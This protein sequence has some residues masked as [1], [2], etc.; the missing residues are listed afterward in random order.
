MIEKAGEVIPAVVSVIKSK[1]S[2]QAQ[3]YQMPTTCPVCGEPAVQHKGEVALRCENLQCPAQTIR[4]LRH[5]ASRN[6]LDIE[7]LGNIVAEKLIEN[8]LVKSPLDLFS[9]TL[10]QLAPLNLGTQKEPRIFGAK[11]AAKLLDAVERA[12]TMPLDR[13]LFALGIPRIGKTV[14]RQIAEAHPHLEA[15]VKSDI[16]H[17]ICRLGSLQEK[18]AAINPD[19]TGDNRPKNQEE[20]A[21]RISQLNE[22]NKNILGIVT[23]LEKA[24][25]L[26]KKEIKTKK[27]GV[28]TIEIQTLIKQDAARSITKFF[29]SARGKQ[30]LNQLR[31]LKIN[32]QAKVTTAGNALQGKTFVLTGTLTTM[33]RD[34]AAELIRAQGGTV[35]N[36][37]T[38]KTTYLVAG[39]NTGAKKTEQAQQHGVEIIDETQLMTMLKTEKTTPAKK[40]PVQEQ[41]TLF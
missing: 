39:A 18:A 41:L 15:V 26:E 19:A 36:T 16:L 30:T 10:N 8:E 28:Q 24:G 37:V 1:R 12:R 35:T 11:N 21:E 7:A 31:E 20:R 32:P 17:N 33:K 29:E 5:F 3:P 34:E 2:P 40:P 22:L 23:E 4:L 6:C 13:W 25:Q 27:N 38:G 9:L 14:A